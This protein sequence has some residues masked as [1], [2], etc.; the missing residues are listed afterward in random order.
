MNRADRRKFHYLYKTTRI[1][2]GRFYIGLHSTD[3]MDDGYMG[4]GK[5]IRRS[6]NKHG[7]SAH[8]KEI[9]EFLPSRA[10]LTAREAEVVNEQLLSDPRCMNI[11]PGGG[12]GVGRPLP[13]SEVA[14]Q[15]IA[16]A[17]RGQKRTDETR[18]KMSEAKIGKKFTEEHKRKIGEMRRKYCESQKLIAFFLAYSNL[19]TS[20]LVGPQDS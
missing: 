5:W 9:L 14:R 17:N 15:K 11:V 20:A 10:S 1:H 18:R 12:G 19:L 8:T 13:C 2:D 4:S 16:E 7:V 6:L 3:D